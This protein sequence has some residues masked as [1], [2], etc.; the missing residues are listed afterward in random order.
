ME[1]KFIPGIGLEVDVETAELT[2]EQNM[3]MDIERQIQN[4]RVAPKF[5][6]WR[7]WDDPATQSIYKV[8]E[9]GR[10]AGAK[11]WSVASLLVQKYNYSKVKLQCLC[12]R[13]YM[14]S[15]AESSYSLIQKTIERLGYERHWELTREYIRNTRNGSYFIF[16]GMRDLKATMQLKSYEGFDDLFAD[17]AAAISLDSWS[18]IVPTLRK[19]TKQ[20]WVVFNRELEIDPC[21]DFFIKNERPRTSILHL[22]PGPVDNPWWGET[23]LQ[24]DMDADYKR[25]FDEAEHIWRGL[26]RSQ[27]QKCI[28]SRTAIRQAMNRLIDNPDGGKQCGVDVARYGDDNTEMY[29]RK[30]M[31][32]I[33]HKEL[34]KADTVLVANAVWD[35]V[36][37]DDTIP[38]FID[39]GYNPGVADML[40]SM[41][42]NVV[43]INFGGEPEDKDRYGSTADELWFNFPIEEAQIPDDSDLMFQLS[44]RQYGYD[45]KNRRRVE[46]KDEYKK[47][48][49]HSPDKADALLLTYYSGPVYVGSV[50]DYSIDDLGV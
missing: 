25:D 12:V 23:T 36:D 49:G 17:E 31:K 20:I 11:S 18:I 38:I 24:E 37:R 14:N 10:G 34:R 33:R 28:W 32:V 16:R 47:R 48:C 35:F 44:A 15:L 40:K 9:G 8:G 39:V 27:G 21:W 22:E 2:L 29:M 45:N 50:A 30:G 4:E 26:P 13:E 6:A 5:E 19:R 42:A 43:E 41:G 46:K 1:A 7:D 3:V